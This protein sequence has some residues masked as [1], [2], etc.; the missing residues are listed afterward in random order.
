MAEW[1]SVKDRLPD[2][3]KRVVV[4]TDFKRVCIGK[5]LGGVSC[6]ISEKHDVVHV[7]HW[8]P[9]SEPPKGE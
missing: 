1:I 2:S 8:M 6:W 3:G 9:L 5:W 7:T 4:Y